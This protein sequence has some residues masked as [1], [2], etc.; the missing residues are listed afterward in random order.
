ME[1]MIFGLNHKTAPIAL[2]ERLALSEEEA[3]VLAHELAQ[4]GCEESALLSTCNRVE[5]YGVVPSQK[6]NRDHQHAVES[7]QDRLILQFS[8]RSGLTVRELQ[9][10]LYIHRERAAITHLF[11]VAAS[12]D[13]MVVGE[14]Q[15]L[16]QLKEA[17][18]RSQTE[19]HSAQG[20]SRL[21][22]RA[23]A[24]A[25]KVRSQTGI[26][27]H[28]VS[29]SS[30]AVGLA[31]QIFGDLSGQT[32]L[33]IGAGEMG[34]LA[35]RHLVQAGIKRLLVANRS[36]ERANKL[37][38][39]L[40]GHP[41]SLNELGT[42]LI[43]ADIVI[44]ST[45]A[46]D[47]LITPDV[48][49]SALKLRKY[50]PI[51]MIDISVPRNISPMVNE[52]DNVYVYDVD[53]LTGIANENRAS[54]ARE[55]EQAEQLVHAE[56]D[57]FYHE[58]ATRDIAPTIV[59][60]REYAHQLKERERLHALKKLGALDEDQLKVVAQFGE[61]LTNK[62]LHSVSMGIKSYASDP[63]REYALEVIHRLFDIDELRSKTQQEEKK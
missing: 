30:V 33:L 18:E 62:L 50:R 3:D 1:L 8:Q 45:G 53:D 4:S 10:H 7:L 29:I 23:F 24:V 15:I 20:L 46:R 26:G 21:M 61:R 42:L 28:V 44:T 41:R 51:I 39:E 47:Y 35:A 22:E 52:I 59:A 40:G 57:R 36:I 2:R 32:A 17:L 13:S 49:Q 58:R 11:R 9:G 38:N 27:R 16:G 37:A 63:Q 60:V 56:V 6:E 54:R 34:E 43:E 25:K 48:A 55:A 14:P 31:K 5:V 19:G 12:L